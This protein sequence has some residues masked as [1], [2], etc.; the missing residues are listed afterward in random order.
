MF[1]GNILICKSWNLDGLAHIWYIYPKEFVDVRLYHMREDQLFVPVYQIV[2]VASISPLICHSFIYNYPISKNSLA[3]LWIEC[4]NALYIFFNRYNRISTNDVHSMMI[5]F[6]HQANI[7]IGFKCRW[8]SNLKFLIHQ[9]KTLPVKVIET[10][11]CW[12]EFFF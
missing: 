2:M 11:T 10:H 6:Y 7:S 9:H 1:F 5:A 12:R 8:G 3:V 4:L